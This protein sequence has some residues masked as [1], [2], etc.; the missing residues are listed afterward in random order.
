MKE[1]LIIYAI[2]IAVMSII[3][4]IFY[5]ADKRKAIKGKWRI[6]EATLLGLSFFGGAVGGILAMNI[7]RH[8]TKHWYFWAVNI[9]A[10]IIHITLPIL[11]CIFVIGVA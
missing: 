4:F 5:Y 9:L 6:P 11:L 2:I 10:L 3:T 8:K 7:F 1:F